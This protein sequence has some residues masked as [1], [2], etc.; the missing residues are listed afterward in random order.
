MNLQRIDQLSEYDNETL[1]LYCPVRDEVHLV[2]LFLDYHRHLGIKLFVFVDN[3]SVDGTLEYLLA[4]PDC[5]VYETN[6]SYPESNF[7]ADWITELMSRH[8]LSQWA[9]YLDCDELLVYEGCE[10]I[11]VTEFLESYRGTNFESFAGIILDIY[12]SE[13]NGEIELYTYE[14]FLKKIFCVDS[15]YVV[16]KYPQK[17]WRKKYRSI[18]IIGGPRCRLYSNVD[19]DLKRGWI[20]YFIAGQ[21]DRIVRFVPLSLMPLLARIWPR[22]TFA[23]YKKPINHI[24]DGFRY[25]SSHNSTNVK[26][27]PYQLGILHLKFSKELMQKIEPKFSYENHYQRGLER[28]RLSGAMRRRKSRSFIYAH[29]IQ[30]EGSQT[31]AEHSIIGKKPGKVWDETSDFFR[32]SG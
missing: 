29:S 25:T 17:P 32:S 28:F 18:E 4:Q 19:K 9:I 15:D 13:P 23:Q 14:D 27:A 20:T 3:G 11:T 5:I 31:L 22:P 10:E 7:A 24:K 6:D 2:P 30:Y 8:S 16:R 21:V 12:S 26:T 1:K